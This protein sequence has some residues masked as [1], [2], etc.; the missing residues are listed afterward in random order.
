MHAALMQRDDHGN[1]VLPTI[2]RYDRDLLELLASRL[3]MPIIYGWLGDAWTP[4]AEAGMQRWLAE[5]P[6]GRF[7]QHR[8]SLAEWGVTPHLQTLLDADG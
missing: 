6:Q 7:G 3:G 1:D 5:N 4:A 2:R 8:Y